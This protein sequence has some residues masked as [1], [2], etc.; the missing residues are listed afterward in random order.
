MT[1]LLD[2]R[3]HQVEHDTGRVFCGHPH[4]HLKT[5]GCAIRPKALRLPSQRTRNR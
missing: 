2:D 1:L 3:A 5:F 4:K